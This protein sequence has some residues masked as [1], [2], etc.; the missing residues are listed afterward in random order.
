MT[1]TNYSTV[2]HR[3]DKCCA[4]MLWSFY[5]QIKR[6]HGWK[7]KCGCLLVSFEHS[8]NVSLMFLE[9]FDEN[10][11]KI[12]N[13]LSWGTFPECFPNVFENV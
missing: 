11:Q 1:T 5:I 2:L 7:Q 3:P 12:L 6:N 9:M 4:Q 10:I 8:L 13:R